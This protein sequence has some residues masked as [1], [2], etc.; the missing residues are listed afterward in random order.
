MI[1][2][3]IAD[4]E[5]LALNGLA[6]LIS[7]IDGFNVCYKADN[8]KK[9]FDYIKDNPANLLITD[10]K[11]P[12]YDGV[13]LINEIEKNNIA[14]VIIVVSAYDDKQ[15]LFRAIK[16][17]YVCDYITKPFISDELIELV[18]N[19]GKYYDSLFSKNVS[20]KESILI[21]SILN[22]NVESIINILTSIFT[23]SSLEENKT[24][25]FYYA[26]IVIDELSKKCNKLNTKILVNYMNDVLLCNSEEELIK[27]S[28]AFYERCSLSFNTNSDATLLIKQSLSIIND[29]IDNPDL[30][31]NMV[32]NIM[33]VTP[34]YLSNKFSRDMNQTFS[35]YLTDLRIKLAKKM[36]LSYS[37]KVFEVGEK[38]GYIDRAYFNKVFKEKTG[39]TPK[40]FRERQISDK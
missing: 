36:L 21:N 24:N 17:P 15:Y 1:N 10:I 16:S 6:S 22:G 39:E 25:C 34:N 32:A 35:N 28:T 5:P 20:F 33:N 3:V 11:M 2:V 8:G 18:K 12:N 31:L 19:A 37:N 7:D 27:V 29:N 9:A 4:D 14:L 38:V 13:W 23:G 26:K 40:Q 30:N